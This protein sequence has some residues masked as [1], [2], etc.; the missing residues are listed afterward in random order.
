VFENNHLSE[1]KALVKRNN[2]T[3]RDTKTT[4][5][6]DR[7]LISK[8]NQ[9]QVDLQEDIDFSIACLYF[10][11]PKGVKRVY[12]EVWGQFFQ[13]IYRGNAHYTFKIPDGTEATYSY[14]NGV[15][16]QVVTTSM[17]GEVKFVKNKTIILL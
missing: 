13:V 12:S 4:Y 7:Y 14:Q 2:K 11:E 10:K 3:V 6:P 1:S 16:E 8:I 15:L 9:Q 5:L 17:I